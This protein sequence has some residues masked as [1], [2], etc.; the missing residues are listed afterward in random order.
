MLSDF[1]NADLLQDYLGQ[2]YLK[3]KRETPH[4]FSISNKIIHMFYPFLS[5]SN[6]SSKTIRKIITRHTEPTR[7]IRSCLV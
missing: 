5:A 2:I 7:F 1:A 4:R 3:N 6:H